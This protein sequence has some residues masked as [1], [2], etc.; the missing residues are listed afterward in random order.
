MVQQAVGLIETRFAQ[1]ITLRNLVEEL[2]FSPGYLS[3]RIKQQTGMN[4]SEY[5]L[6]VRLREA[7]RMLLQTNDKIA[8]IAEKVGYADPFYLSRLF[9]QVTGRT[10]SEFRRHGEDRK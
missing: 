9:K 2:Q 1:P 7:R 4:F 3:V 5:L 6:H 10:P 8:E